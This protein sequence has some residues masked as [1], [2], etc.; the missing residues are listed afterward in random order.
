M[1]LLTKRI[2][3]SLLLILLIFV[4]HILISTGFFRSVENNFEGTVLKEISIKGAED[5]TVNI[6]EGFALISSTNREIYPP[7]ME[8][9]GALYFMDLK[10]NSFNL[11]NLTSS[12]NKPFAPHGISMIKKDST[13]T[14]MAINHTP[15]GHSIEVF[16]M[17]DKNLI[18]KKTL[19]HPSLISPNDLV[20]IDENRFY[21]TNDHKYTDGFGKILEEYL[22]LSISNVLYYDGENYIEVADGIAYANGINF[23]R[24]RNLLYVAS[25][26]AFLVKAY[27]KKDDGTLEFIEDI[28]CNTG[29]DNIEIDSEG[30]LWIGAHPNLLRFGS[31]AKGKKET[32]PSEI[33]KITYNGKNDYTIKQQYTDDGTGMS[34]STVATP[35][36]NLIITGNV[37]DDHFLILKVKK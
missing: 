15:K 17:Q 4:V 3:L 8:E 24:K 27:T 31:Y 19:K 35:Y 29:V 16:S 1:K 6:S 12:F 30:N 36:K 9:K 23:D 13:Y 22:G 33:I 18:H 14:I 7:I 20:L 26:R 28:P 5:I 32:S 25:P 37:M 34:G 21:I 2:A 11:T 10:D